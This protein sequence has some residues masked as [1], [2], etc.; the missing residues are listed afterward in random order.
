SAPFKVQGLDCIEGQFS[1]FSSSLRPDAVSVRPS[2][3]PACFG[4]PDAAAGLISAE[5]L[6]DPHPLA[7]SVPT[8]SNGSSAANGAATTPSTTAAPARAA[9]GPACTPTSG[10]LNVPFAYKGERSVKMR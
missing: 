4:S 6:N 3:L 2:A 8:F 7:S 1:R 5:V 10:C 9:N